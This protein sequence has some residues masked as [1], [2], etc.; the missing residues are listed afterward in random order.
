M[1]ESCRLCGANLFS[2]IVARRLPP[3]LSSDEFINI[4]GPLGE[5][6]YFEF[7]PGD[8]SLEPHAFSRYAIPILSKN[9]ELYGHVNNR[10]YINFKNDEDLFN[11]RNRFDGYVFVDG[12]GNDYHAVVEFATYQKVPLCKSRVKKDPKVGTIFDDPGKATK[13]DVQQCFN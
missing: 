4:V 11:F 9:D 10:A 7:V 3:K 5:H 6:S 13:K 1:F 2:Q 12:R 8:L